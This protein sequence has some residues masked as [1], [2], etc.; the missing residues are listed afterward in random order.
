MFAGLI[1]LIMWL[2][3]CNKVFSYWGQY[4]LF[5]IKDTKMML[6]SDGYAAE[7]KYS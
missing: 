7:L 2:P 6:F 3:R 1:P 5:L 4:K